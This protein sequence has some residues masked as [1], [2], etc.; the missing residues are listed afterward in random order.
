MNTVDSLTK[1]D[2]CVW[3]V[4]D[5]NGARWIVNLDNHTVRTATEHGFWGT[6]YEPLE[7]DMALPRVGE[8]FADGTSVRHIMQLPEMAPV[9]RRF[10]NGVSRLDVDFGWYPLVEDMHTRLVETGADS[11]YDQIKEKFGELRVYMHGRNDQAR[12]IIAAAR[13]KARTTCERCGDIARMRTQRQWFQTLCDVCSAAKGC[14]VI[15]IGDT[16]EEI[17]E[18][19]RDVWK[20]TTQGSEHIWDMNNRTYMRLPGKESRAGTFSHDGEAQPITHVDLYPKVGGFS[21]V[22]FDDPDFPEH[23]ELFRQSSTITRIERVR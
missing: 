21:R 15:G 12:V 10:K 17:T 18:D 3:L 1:T 8:P 4:S 7:R 22:W 6:D 5:E 16:V 2:T 9:A 23:V 11:E 14:D 19:M 13:Q 20:V